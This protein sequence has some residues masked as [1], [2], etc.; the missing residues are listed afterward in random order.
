[1]ELLKKI[2]G[3][4]ELVGR[5]GG[6][7]I[8]YDKGYNTVTVWAKH[9]TMHL[10]TGEAF[11]SHGRSRY[12][13]SDSLNTGSDHSATGVGQGHNPDGTLLSGQQYF[14]ANATGGY[15]EDT[16]WT[17]STVNTA[18][19]DGDRSDTDS[20]MKFPFFPSKML[21]GTGFEYANWTSIPSDYKTYFTSLGWDSST[22]NGNISLSDN[23]YSNAYS[24]SLT[25]KRTMND[26]YSAAI[27]SPTITDTDFGI[28]G[29][30]KNGTYNDSA[31]EREG[32]A[33]PKTYTDGSQEYLTL[34]YQGIGQPCFIYAKR[35]S[36]FFN[37]G[38]EIQLS[39]DSSIENKI[40]YTVVLPEQTSASAGIFYPYNGYTI[41]VAGLFADAAFTLSNTDPSGGAANIDEANE[42]ANYYKQPYGIMFA[43][44]YVAPFTK[45]ADV[46]LTARWTL[47]L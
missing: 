45:T 11:S 19:A 27:S 18:T 34:A 24:G 9:A 6:E 1:M 31:T 33:T 36:R 25:K 17:Q 13:D 47:Y 20:E 38:A 14:T 26:I 16:M 22:F 35:Q 44:R 42:L 21:F 28:P 5:R 37:G 39:A 12:F 43:K 2:T 30:V 4:L 32:E 46:S 40:T 10:L 15:A 3:E 23:D 8:Y 7:V 41:K 29:A